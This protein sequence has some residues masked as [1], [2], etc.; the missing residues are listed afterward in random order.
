MAK[1]ELIN[2]AD[3]LLT[4]IDITDLPTDHCLMCYL[5]EDVEEMT[6]ITEEEII[7]PYLEKLKAELTKNYVNPDDMNNYTYTTV[8]LKSVLEAIDNLLTEGDTE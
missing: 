6:T 2:K 8:G 7:K 4:P 3:L 1:R 5:Q